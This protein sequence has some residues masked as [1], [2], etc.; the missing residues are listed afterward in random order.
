MLESGKLNVFDCSKFTVKNAKADTSEFSKAA[1]ITM[2][3]NGHL[4]GY[5]ADV[6]DLG[7]YAGETEVVVNGVFKESDK[8]SA[9]YF[10]IIID[11]I[12]VGAK[13]DYSE[14]K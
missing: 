7:D 10:D 12:S 8:R 9:P 6:I 5:K 4:T 14:D 13:V 2:D 3:E 11:G 1:N